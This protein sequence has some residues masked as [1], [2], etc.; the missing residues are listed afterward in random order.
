M[1]VDNSWRKQKSR[2]DPA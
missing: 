2:L 1:L